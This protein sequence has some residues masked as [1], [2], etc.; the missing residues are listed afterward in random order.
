M[1][2]ED[3]NREIGL[4]EVQVTID[5]APRPFHAQDRGAVGSEICEGRSGLGGHDH[6]CG[7]RCDH[8]RR[9]GQRANRRRGGGIP[10]CVC[11]DARSR[12][13]VRD[14]VALRPARD[15]CPGRR[16]CASR[17]RSLDSLRGGRQPR[18]AHHAA[19]P[20]P[21]CAHPANNQPA[22]FRTSRSAHPAP[23]LLRG[24]GHRPA[25]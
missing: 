2:N 19:C 25:P 16:L 8:P 6:G 22:R 10:D 3:R 20:L 15:R 14:S 9:S 21:V 18:D 13:A 24:V 17:L 12:G 5:V 1:A 4:G 11:A 7:D 23:A